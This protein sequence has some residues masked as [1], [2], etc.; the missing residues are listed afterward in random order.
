M[1]RFS[2]SNPGR[3]FVKMAV[4]TDNIPENVNPGQWLVINGKRARLAHNNRVVYPNGKHP[5]YATV[6]KTGFS[7][8]CNKLPRNVLP[9]GPVADT[10]KAIME[11]LSLI[12]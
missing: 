7:L 12:A 9:V 5:K 11:L 3:P 1:A 2:V 6:S 4:A 10:T 8:A